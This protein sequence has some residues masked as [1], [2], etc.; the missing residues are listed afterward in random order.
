MS[1]RHAPPAAAFCSGLWPLRTRLEAKYLAGRIVIGEGGAR[2]ALATLSR[3]LANG[4]VVSVTMGNQASQVKAIPF[5]SGMLT[6]ATRPIFL[7]RETGAIILPVVTVRADD[8]TIETEIGAPLML[9]D[10]PEADIDGIV[11]ERLGRFL[12]PHVAAHPDQ[13]ARAYVFNSSGAKP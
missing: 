7:A 13:Y 5:M 11:V 12:E 3:H 9:P 1:A 8:G 10:D 4:E 2:E 6:I